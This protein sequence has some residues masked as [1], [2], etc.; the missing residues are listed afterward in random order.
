MHWRLGTGCSKGKARGD[1]A[2]LGDWSLPLKS[3]EPAGERALRGE[4]GGG[5]P[6]LSS[7]RR[8]L[9][10]TRS[11]ETRTGETM[12]PPCAPF[13][14]SAVRNGIGDTEGSSGQ[15]VCSSKGAG[16]AG[17]FVFKPRRRKARRGAGLS[18]GMGRWVAFVVGDPP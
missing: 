18:R 14:L 6:L 17:T 16:Q 8:V 13:F 4:W 5:S 10:I 11:S 3:E 9:L 7:A 2:L 1:R 15:A 12:F